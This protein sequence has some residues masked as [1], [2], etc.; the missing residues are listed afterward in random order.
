MKTR[1]DKGS[2]TRRKEKGDRLVPHAEEVH[3][4]GLCNCG[5]GSYY[6]VTVDGNDKALSVFG[7]DKEG[8]R[9]FMAGVICQIESEESNGTQGAHNTTH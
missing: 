8:W 9:N 5:C 6:A 4:I 2:W 1:G 7:W 3:W